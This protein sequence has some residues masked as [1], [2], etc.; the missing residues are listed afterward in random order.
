MDL[1]AA[2]RVFDLRSVGCA[3]IESRRTVVITS[4]AAGIGVMLFDASWLPVILTM[5]FG[6][7]C[8]SDLAHPYVF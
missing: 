1:I 4:V 5:Q 7:F 3:V 2:A 6:P 8:Y